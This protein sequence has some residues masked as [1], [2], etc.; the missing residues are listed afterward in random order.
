[1]AMVLSSSKSCDTAYLS[2]IDTA[3]WC[4]NH[5]FP[6][7]NLKKDTPGLD[8][9]TVDATRGRPMSREVVYGIKDVW[10]DMVRD[11]EERS[12]TIV[13]NS[14][15]S[16]VTTIIDLTSLYGVV[17]YDLNFDDVPNA[18]QSFMANILSY[19]SDVLTEVNNQDNMD[20]NMINQVVQAMPSF[21]QSS[22]VNHSET[23]ITS[24]SNI[25]PYFQYV[26]ESQQTAV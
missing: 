25:I 1:Q 19:G 3:Y 20:N 21:E 4:Q 10:D 12:P 18:Q 24:D 23:E 8:V 17:V 14:V 7:H 26:I 2:R 16:E 9:A 13:R 11:M 15:F 5:Y 6:G 22:V